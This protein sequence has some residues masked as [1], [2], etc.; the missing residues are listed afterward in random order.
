[1][2]DA[3]SEARGVVG[4]VVRAHFARGRRVVHRSGR[5]ADWED[6]ERRLSVR[7]PI[8]LLVGS[9]LLLSDL[10]GG[11]KL[12]APV[13]LLDGGLA[14]LPDACTRTKVRRGG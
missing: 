11:N 6:A 12:L 9:G 8:L 3:R 5:R 2:G 4:L 1:M 14:K 13:E 10:V 7:M